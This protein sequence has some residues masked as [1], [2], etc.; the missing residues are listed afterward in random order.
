[1]EEEDQRLLSAAHAVVREGQRKLHALS[2]EARLLYQQRLREWEQCRHSLEELASL[3]NSQASLVEA[4]SQ[5]TTNLEARSG[6][7]QLETQLREKHRQMAEDVYQIQRAVRL[8]NTTVRRL[9]KES[10][11]L[12]QGGD[13]F[14]LARDEESQA[15]SRERILQAYE[16]ERLRLAREIHDGPAQ[17]LANT[18]FEME[19][20][21]R[22][23]DRDPGALRDQLAQLKADMRDGL[24]E[25]RRFIFELRPPSLSEVGLFEALQGYL[26]DFG[27]HFGL[28][29]EVDL[30]RTQQRLAATKEVALFRIVQEALQNVQKHAGASKIAVTGKLNSGLLHLSI[31]DN[32]RGFALAE[33]ASRQS[34]NLGLISMRERAELIDAQLEVNSAPGRGTKLVLVVP[35]GTV[36]NRQRPK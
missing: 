19:Y 20:V 6:L 3:L 2:E 18:I 13:G 1:M 23:A 17:V 15:D 12:L 36:S 34:K 25:V 29:V 4:D 35:L 32:G 16:Q 22:V 27:K 33:V 7:L 31:E 26:E 10:G 21:E 30:P 9:E 28:T 11:R 5:P 14:Y 8:L 24:T